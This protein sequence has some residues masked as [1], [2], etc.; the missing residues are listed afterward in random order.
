MPDRRST[1]ESPWSLHGLSIES[2]SNLHGLSIE[3]PSRKHRL[4]SDEDP[5]IYTRWSESED[6]SF[7]SRSLKHQIW[8]RIEDGGYPARSTAEGVGGL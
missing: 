3:S 6:L 7:R 5:Y 4:H 1:I 2:P 8:A